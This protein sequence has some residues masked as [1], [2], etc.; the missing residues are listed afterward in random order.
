MSGEDH[1]LI[2]SIL[3]RL[4][5]DLAVPDHS[6][7]SRRA[8]TV[9]VPRPRPGRRPVH[10]LID[11]KGLKL[12]GP[13][14]W[15]V[16]RHGGTRRRPCRNLHIATDADTGRI[17]AVELIPR[18]L[19]PR[20]GCNWRALV[21]TDVSRWNRIIGHGLWSRTADRQSTE[22]A[23]AADVLKRML[24]LGQPEYVRLA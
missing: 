11:S 8:R 4:G 12:C 16:E 9:E 3:R 10:L 6:K 1:T 13:D 23:V 18:G 20:S 2:R 24:K 19:Q 22:V 21:E 7:M 15:L 14:E 17:A 5:L